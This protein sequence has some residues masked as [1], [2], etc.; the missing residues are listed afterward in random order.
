MDILLINKWIECSAYFRKGMS[1][2]T[3]WVTKGLLA[4]VGS[5]LWAIALIHGAGR[6][7]AQA[8]SVPNI[9]QAKKFMLMDDQGKPTAVLTNFGT[10][11]P[12]LMMINSKGNPGLLLGVDNTAGKAGSFIT[13]YNDQGNPG[14]K[15]VMNSK[16]QELYMISPNANRMVSLGLV[17]EGQGLVLNNKTTQIRTILDIDKAGGRLTSTYL[18][19]S[20]T[21]E[22]GVNADGPLV[23]LTDGNNKNQA[24]LCVGGA[25]PSLNFIDS[26]GIPRA[27]LNLERDGPNLMLSNSKGMPTGTFDVLADGPSIHLDDADGAPRAWFGVSKDGA[28]LEIYD[29]SNSSAVLGVTHNIDKVT[30]AKTPT[31]AS[32]I[33]LYDANRKILFQKP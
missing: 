10:S 8:P 4:F 9:I 7:D 1:M 26:K 17:K 28:S 3:D 16:G 22:C 24:M 13:M 15:L 14:V 18:K 33:T 32:T 21:Y 11:G 27:E 25:G 2:K 12:G 31:K 23:N 5:G 20:S 30:G 29:K 19:N 6:V